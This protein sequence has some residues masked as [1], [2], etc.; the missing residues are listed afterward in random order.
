MEAMLRA[1]KI[2]SGRNCDGTTSLK[3]WGLIP[4]TI[5]IHSKDTDGRLFLFE[6]NDMGKGGPPRHIHFEQEEFFY[7]T[8]GTFAFEIGDQK[9]TLTA[10]DSLMAPRGVPHAWACTCDCGSLL[11]MLTP[12]GP[13]EKFILDTTR[14]SSLPPQDE[15]VKAFADHGMHVVGPPLAV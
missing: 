6:H 13:F 5:K 10:G 12:A 1:A 11:T 8:K 9:F 3:I 15:V 14:Y 4:L 2:P 7:V